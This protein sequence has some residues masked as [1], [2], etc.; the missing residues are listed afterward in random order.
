MGLCNPKDGGLGC[1]SIVFLSSI[2]EAPDSIPTLW[3][4]GWNLTPIVTPP[5]PPVGLWSMGQWEVSGLD[6]CSLRSI[7]L[8]VDSNWLGP[9]PDAL[10]GCGAALPSGSGAPVVRTSDYPSYLGLLLRLLQLSPGTSQRKFP[11]E[12]YPVHYDDAGEEQG[13]Y[14]T[15]EREAFR[16][17]ERRPHKLRCRHRPSKP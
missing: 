7:G 16:A 11:A 13:R 6:T 8:G 1:G 9:V 5:D 17:G 15:F 14:S 4:G 12:M 10:L 2:H 3:G